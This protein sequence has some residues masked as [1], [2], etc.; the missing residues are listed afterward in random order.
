MIEIVIHDYAPDPD[1]GGNKRGHWGNTA[2]AIRLARELGFA[3]ALKWKAELGG[4]F[5][6][7]YDGPLHV[8]YIVQGRTRMD[9]DNMAQ[10][11]KPILDGIQDAGLISD[12][13][14]VTQLTISRM[15]SSE[16][17]LTVKIRRV[18]LPHLVCASAR[19]EFSTRTFT[20]FYSHLS[21]EHGERLA[22][23]SVF[24]ETL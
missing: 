24:G 16:N 22:A 20:E 23:P 3:Y 21:R 8:A 9:I 1:I 11:L 2:S 17:I 10:A 6:L 18:G 14:E 5:S 12:D 13:R 7:P 4:G 19:C 15:R